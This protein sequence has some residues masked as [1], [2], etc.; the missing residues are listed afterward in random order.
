MLF[1]LITNIL[2][3]VFQNPRI[4]EDRD[5]RASPSRPTPLSNVKQGE[6]LHQRFKRT[7]MNTAQRSPRDNA[8]GEETSGSADVRLDNKSKLR[9]SKDVFKP[10]TPE[11]SSP[12]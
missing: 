2:L 3:L 12:E 6:R 10:P 11:S 5:I 8:S 7:L 4:Y 1:S 9:K